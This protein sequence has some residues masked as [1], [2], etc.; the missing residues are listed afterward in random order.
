MVPTMHFGPPAASVGKRSI[1]YNVC[2]FLA[3]LGLFAILEISNSC[4]P[5]STSTH[6]ASTQETR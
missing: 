1:L 5:C 6:A 3:F 2:G 4:V